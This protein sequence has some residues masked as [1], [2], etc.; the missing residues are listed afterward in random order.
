MCIVVAYTVI[1]YIITLLFFTSD[2]TEAVDLPAKTFNFL[3]HNIVY[4][5]NII[6]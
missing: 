3:Y 2:K 5:N 4:N 6:I 1:Y